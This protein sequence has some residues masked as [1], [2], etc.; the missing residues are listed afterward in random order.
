[1]AEAQAEAADL[2]QLLLWLAGPRDR[3]GLLA[4]LGAVVIDALGAVAAA[5]AGVD[6]KDRIGL[7]EAVFHGI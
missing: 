7:V 4:A 3:E 1:M 6:H 5:L 2:A